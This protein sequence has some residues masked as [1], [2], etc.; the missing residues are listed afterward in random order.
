MQATKGLWLIVTFLAAS[1]SVA[2]T[3]VFRCLGPEGT[4]YAKRFDVRVGETCAE[5]TPKELARRRAEL[6]RPPTPAEKQKMD[7]RASA[8]DFWKLCG[9]LG[10]VLRRPDTTPKGQY[11]EGAVI[12]AA[13]IPANDHGYIRDRRLRVGMDECSVVAILGKPDTLNRTNFSGG[14]DD[15]FVYRDKGIYVYTRNGIVRAWQE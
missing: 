6:A 14:R 4:R 13:K 15:Q 9:E 5:L 11:W 1:A 8:M 10:R 7:K 3:N 12:A 2:Q